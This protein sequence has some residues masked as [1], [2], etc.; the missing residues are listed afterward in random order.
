I[1]ARLCEPSPGPLV[2][3]NGQGETVKVESVCAW[4]GI[5]TGVVAISRPGPDSLRATTNWPENSL[6][7]LFSKCIFRSKSRKPQPLA[8]LVL[9]SDGV[10]TMGDGPLRVISTGG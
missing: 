10:T 8:S 7:W 2:T 4:A 3:K 5:T 9:F 6:S 1:T